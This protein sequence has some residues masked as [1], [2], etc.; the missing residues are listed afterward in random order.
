MD[1]KLLR[2]L[3]F[4]LVAAAVLSS[5]GDG[6]QKKI[7]GHWSF[8]YVTHHSD[9]TKDKC[10]VNWE[11]RGDG[12]FKENREFII[13][14]DG[15]Y[16]G[17]NIHCKCN[18]SVSGTYEIVL[19]MLTLDYDIGSLSVSAYPGSVSV[20]NLQRG[21]YYDYDDKADVADNVKS[22]VYGLLFDSYNEHNESGI[23]VIDRI[24]DKVLAFEDDDIGL[25][26]AKRQ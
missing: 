21:Y 17:E 24:T 10:T 25:V 22:Y 7:I 5:C 12:H 1:N 18:S 15:L 8:G 14:C 4:V 3:I 20:T 16:G 6:H 23:F 13:E 19:G 26:E 2:R 9:M 11:F